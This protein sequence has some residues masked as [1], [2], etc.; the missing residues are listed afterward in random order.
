MARVNP[1]TGGFACVCYDCGMNILHLSPYYAPAYPF[2]G[3]VRAVEGMATALAARGHSVTVLTTDAYDP[4]S[5][6]AAPREETRDGVHVVRLPNRFIR[7]TLNVSTPRGLSAAAERLIAQ[8]D[9]L[10]VHEFR[11]VE[12]LIATPRAK[13]LGK[14][15]VL[16]PHGTLTLATGRSAV[17]AAWDRLFSAAVARRIRAVIALTEREA[18]DARAFWTTLGVAGAS[19]EIVPNGVDPVLLT[20]PGDGAAFRAR[21]G[22]GD[23]PIVLFLGRL[24]PRKGAHLLAQAFA[25][26]QQ[27]NARLVV[28]GPDEGGRELV[29]AAADDRTVL[30]GYLGPAERL[31]ALAAADV[32]ALPATGEGLSMAL[33]EALAFGVPALVAPGASLPELTASGAGIEVAPDIPALAAA[34]SELLGDAEARR[35]MGAAAQ[36]LVAA[37]FTWPAVAAQL[38]A[39]YARVARI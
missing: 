18:M 35:A 13:R 33:L 10:H 25:Q 24:H 34:L 11:T 21:Y 31:D 26:V 7:G 22:L 29:E 36:R 15:V 20:G 1:L 4:H 9:V 32:F 14:P 38:E 3:V 23:G 28:V 8:A 6:S 5:R 37:R 16:S 12:N 27:P 39:V 17:K 30:V 2:G 19:F